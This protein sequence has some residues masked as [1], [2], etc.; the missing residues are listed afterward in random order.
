[1]VTQSRTDGFHCRESAG[2]VLLKHSVLCCSWACYMLSDTERTGGE[3]KNRSD[4]YT[5]VGHKIVVPDFIF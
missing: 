5:V 3:I 2:T 1:M 4:R